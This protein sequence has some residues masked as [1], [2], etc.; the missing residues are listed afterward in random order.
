[1]KDKLQI[2]FDAIGRRESGND[3]KNDKNP[4][5]YLGKYQMGKSALT[6]AGYY[7]AGKYTGKDGVYT[8]KDFLNNPQAQEN[9]M[10]IYKQKQWGY[11][12]GFAPEY[13]GKYINGIHITYSGMLAA[14]HLNGHAK[15]REYLDL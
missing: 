3:Y 11:I 2:Y 8:D 12:K 5:G 14:A 15:L 4:Y 10:R 9:A 1:M 7:F 13:S 6:D